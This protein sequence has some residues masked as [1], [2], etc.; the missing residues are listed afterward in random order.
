MTEQIAATGAIPVLSTIAGDPA[1]YPAL[2]AYNAAIVTIAQK[3]HLPLLNVWRAVNDRAL[4]SGVGPDLSLSTSG[5]GDIFTEEALNTYGV[6]IRN[7]GALRVL[8]QLYAAG[9]LP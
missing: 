6:A 4:T 8:G 3:H 1:L 9:V 2:D 5:T 7:L